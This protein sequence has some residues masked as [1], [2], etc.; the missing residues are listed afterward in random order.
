MLVYARHLVCPIQV[1]QRK[2]GGVRHNDHKA[3]LPVLNPFILL[4]FCQPSPE[5]FKCT[6][7]V[8][9]QFLRRNLLL[10]LPL[11]CA[12]R[13]SYMSLFSLWLCACTH[14]LSD[15]LARAQPSDAPGAK[16]SFLLPLA[17]SLLHPWPVGVTHPN[18]NRHLRT[19][20]ARMPVHTKFRPRSRK[21]SS[22]NTNASQTM[23]NAADTAS[24]RSWQDT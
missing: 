23:K 11:L 7:G 19:T 17:L 22:A 9:A 4:V 18:T 1:A 16:A 14:A 20:E 5:A 10:P 21:K 2:P 24:S 12:F 15:L 8:F 13:R 6:L 3:Q